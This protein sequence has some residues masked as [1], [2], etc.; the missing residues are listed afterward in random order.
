MM[1][2]LLGVPS[3]DGRYEFPPLPPDKY[4]ITVRPIGSNKPGDSEVDLTSGRCR[5]YNAG[6]IS[7]PQDPRVYR[8]FPPF[9]RGAF[10]GGLPPTG[11][12]GLLDAHRIA[13]VSEQAVSHALAE[14]P[15]VIVGRGS[16]YF[17]RNRQDVFRTFLYASRDYKI[18]RLVV[19]GMPERDEIEQVDTTDRD[20]AA[21]IKKYLNLNSFD[22]RMNLPMFNTERGEPTSP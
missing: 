20:R 4:K 13:A 11:R 8:V 9:L 21:L 6:Q 5:G 18:H 22:H 15:C 1:R 10:E 12:L 16:Q 14:G 19:G 17:L 2:M 3:S 7:P